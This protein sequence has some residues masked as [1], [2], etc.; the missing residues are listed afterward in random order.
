MAKGFKPF[1]KKGTTTGKA[2]EKE[3]ASM[4]RSAADK[5]SDKKQMKK[6]KK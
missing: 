5:K 1:A 2:A 3:M 4:E 6:A